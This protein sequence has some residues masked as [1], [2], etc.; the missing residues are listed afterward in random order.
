VGQGPQKLTT[1]SQYNA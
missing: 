1:I